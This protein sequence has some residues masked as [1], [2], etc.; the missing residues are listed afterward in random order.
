MSSYLPESPMGDRKKPFAYTRQCTAASADSS[1]SRANPATDN[2]KDCAICA[3]EAG[4]CIEDWQKDAISSAVP[5]MSCR[6]PPTEKYIFRARRHQMDACR[7][8]VPSPQPAASASMS[9]A[10][11]PARA[12]VR[13]SAREAP[14]ED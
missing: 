7:G 12:A 5:S 6:N 8:C 10:D 2:Q 3:G 9:R 13:K 1:E 4:S 14:R 11:A